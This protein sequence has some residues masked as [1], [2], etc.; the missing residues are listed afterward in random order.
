VCRYQCTI[1]A[2]QSAPAQCRVQQHWA[3]RGILTQDI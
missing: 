1:P 2:Q 3:L